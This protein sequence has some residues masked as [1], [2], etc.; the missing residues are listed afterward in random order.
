MKKNLLLLLCL[1]LCLPM[2]GGSLVNA[3]NRSPIVTYDY[4]HNVWL[5]NLLDQ[6]AAKTETAVR[7]SVDAARPGMASELRSASGHLTYINNPTGLMAESALLK[8]NRLSILPVHAPRMTLLPLP[9][10]SSLVVDM[11]AGVFLIRGNAVL[12]MPAVDL[13][14]GTEVT[15]G[16]PM[17]AGHR[18]LALT[19]GR[20]CHG[21][22]AVLG[23]EGHYRIEKNYAVA[24]R[25]LAMALHQLSLFRGTAHSFELDRLATRDEALVIMLR[26][27]GEE[28]A[29]LAFTGTHPF[30]DVPSW[31]SRYV[32]YAFHNGYTNGVGNNRF[33]TGEPCDYAQFVAMM[34]RALGYSESAD[35]YR[36]RDAPDFAVSLGIY[37]AAEM[38]MASHEFVRDKAVYLS[39]FALEA[40]MKGQ[41]LTLLESLIDAGVF[42]RTQADAAMRTVT[43]ARLR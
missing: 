26:L 25:P 1:V 19:S 7:P 5:K 32:A 30:T 3:S 18:Y 39:Y 16:T 9:N 21:T 40:R 41:S 4:L 29:A 33:G 2:A 28:A 42:T 20:F 13:T 24:F 15:A 6:A 22:N 43:V 27:F 23:L 34:L 17:R 31:A 10:D 37:N 12:S 8:M 38:T 14:A 36:W 35:G 11:G